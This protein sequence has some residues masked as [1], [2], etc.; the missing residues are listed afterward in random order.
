MKLPPV[1][2]LLC[3]LA[4]LLNNTTRAQSK[5]LTPPPPF[6]KGEMLYYNV[7]Y[8]FA[9]GAEVVFSVSDTLIGT[10]QYYHLT[11]DGK[12]TGMV[13]V[14]Y[15]LHDTY[16]AYTDKQTHLP[17]KAVRNV[18]EQSYKDYKV[19]LFDRTSR[20]DSTIVTRENGEMVVLPKEVCDLVSLGYSMRVQLSQTKFTKNTLFFFP[21]Y[22]NAEYFPFGVRYIC[23][24]TICTDFGKVRCHKFIPRIQKGDLFK[25]NDA[26]TIWFSADENHLPIRIEFKLFLGSMVCELKTFRKLV[27]PFNVIP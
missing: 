19:D 23:E 9:K 15:P 2:A 4:T 3:V 14:L 10:K 11:I 21:T 6:Q 8:A 22:F 16:H 26:V 13:G 12:T 7:R 17:I 1:V 20:S 18:H 25:E 24:E 27:S 5:N